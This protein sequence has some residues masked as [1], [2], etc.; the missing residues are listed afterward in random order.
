MQAVLSMLEY[1]Q[2][3]LASGHSLHSCLELQGRHCA[4]A[5]PLYQG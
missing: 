5:W 3:A 1:L 2:V 4:S